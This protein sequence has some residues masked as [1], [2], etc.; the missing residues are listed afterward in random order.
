MCRDGSFGPGS[1]ATASARSTNLCDL[2]IRLRL[3]PGRNTSH[4]PVEHFQHVPPLIVAQ[5][6]APGCIVLNR[7]TYN[8]TLRF[9][10]SGS[11]SA[12]SVDGFRIEGKCDFYHTLPY[13]HTHTLRGG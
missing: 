6:S 10:Q 12:Q 4:H 8:G 2:A 5:A 11:R 9:L 1:P 7:F 3:A 13:Y